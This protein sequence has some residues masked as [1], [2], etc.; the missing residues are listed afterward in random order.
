[1]S[2]PSDWSAL[3]LSSDPTPGDPAVVR[4][5]G[6]SYTG[7]ADAIARAAATLRRLDAGSS[8]ADSVKALLESRDKVVDD[9]G[10]AEGRYRSA[11][12]ALSTYAVTLDRVQVDTLHALSQAR[13]AQADAEAAEASERHYR[14]LADDADDPDQADEHDDYVRRQDAQQRAASAARAR[15]AT[16]VQLVQ[17]AVSDR[18][19]AA[20]TAIDKIENTTSSDGLN[21][22]WWD[23]WGAK[24]TEWIATIAEA[25]ATIA[26]ILALLVCWIP[27]IGQALAGVLLIVAAVAGIVAALANIALAATGEKSWGEA[28]VS[29]VFAV[30]GCVGIGGA[31][32][33]IFAGLRAGARG[34]EAAEGAARGGTAL[35]RGVSLADDG[36][37]EIALRM[38]RGWNADQI[39]A[40][41]QKVADVNAAGPMVSRVA[42]AERAVNVRRLWESVSGKI[43]Q[44]GVDVDH[45]LD[46]QLGGKS[47]IENLQLLD[48]SVNRS[49]GAQINNAIKRA[50][51][52]FGT[53]VRLVLPPSP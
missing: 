6:T 4:D 49:F 51:L 24:L 37:V 52:D 15:I 21:D 36:V 28:V 29:I 46:L 32:R 40:A 1:M 43:T 33:G 16:Q 26:G 41:T 9:V 30:L 48:R 2:R 25:V 31:A 44:S 10:K 42:E 7:V 11:G 8:T 53:D 19:A 47:V 50:Q 14:D 5:G 34:V 20:R 22:S 35:A 39:A 18:D 17:A 3:G 12:Q 27:V 13:A 38:K 45:I 23:D